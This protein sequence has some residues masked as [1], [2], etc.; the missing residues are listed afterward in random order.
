MDDVI[1]S[2]FHAMY[3]AQ[4]FHMAGKNGRIPIT[5]LEGIKKL[6]KDAKTLVTTGIQQRIL[7]ARDLVR[8]SRDCESHRMTLST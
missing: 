2:C 4:W 6:R 1:Q 7:L 3:N 8:S 5:N